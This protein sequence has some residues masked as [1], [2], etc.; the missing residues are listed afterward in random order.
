MDKT[1][2]TVDRGPFKAAGRLGLAPKCLRTYLVNKLHP[3]DTIGCAF[4]LA[5]L[6]SR[7]I[8]RAYD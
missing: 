3:R 1:V 7:S 2:R 5:S 4:A 8:S 6:L